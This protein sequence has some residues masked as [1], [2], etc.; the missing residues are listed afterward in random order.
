MT[1]LTLEDSRKIIA[2]ALAKGR[3]IGLKPLAVLVL[4]AG[5]HVK[6]FER[7]DGASNLR[8][9]IARGKAYGGLGVQAIEEP[10]D[11]GRVRRIAAV[12]LAAGLLGLCGKLGA[13]ARGQS[14]A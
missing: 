3:E 1:A 2:A 5:G 9:E 8:F 10:G 11:R 4:D 12:G 7:E 14:H 6:A 13:V